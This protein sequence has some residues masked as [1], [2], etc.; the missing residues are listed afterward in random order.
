MSGKSIVQSIISVLLFCATIV[1]IVF[2]FKTS[3][4][5][6]IAGIVLLIIPELIRRKALSN[7]SGLIDKLIAKFIVPVLFLVLAFVSIMAAWFWIQ[8]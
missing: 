7:A 4:L 5:L 1:A 2:L 3:I 6:G 8:L